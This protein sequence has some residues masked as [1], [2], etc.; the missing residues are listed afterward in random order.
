MVTIIRM[1]G[2]DRPGSEA[3][4]DEDVMREWGGVELGI[5]RVD[6]DGSVAGL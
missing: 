1:P 2:Q 3:N 5:I 6:V 4:E